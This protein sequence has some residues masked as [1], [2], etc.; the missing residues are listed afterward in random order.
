M[1]VPSDNYD[2]CG[3]TNIGT[4]RDYLFL[5]NIIYIKVA[6]TY[7]GNFYLHGFTKYQICTASGPEFFKWEVWLFI[8]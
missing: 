8:W 3:V 6:A 2:Y 4:A 1:I 7:V 5:V